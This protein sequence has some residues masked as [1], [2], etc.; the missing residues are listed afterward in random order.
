M[1][2]RGFAAAALPPEVEAVP[3]DDWRGRTPMGAQKRAV[4]A[5]CARAPHEARGLLSAIEAT[6]PEALLVDQLA[7]GAIAAA[8]AWGGPWAR[9][10]AFPVP[11]PGG[12]P[13]GPGFPPARGPLGRLRD[14]V[15]RRA[16]DVGLD[17]LAGPPLARVRTELGLPPLAGGVEIFAASPLQVRL[18][19]EPFE[20]PFLEHPD[21]VLM[22]G[23]CVWEPAGE[24]P[25]ELAEVEEPLV[26][27]ATSTEFQDD[28]RL[29]ATALA[30]LADEPLHVVATMPT[31]R[32]GGLPAPANATLLA[33]APHMPI[34]AR[35]ACAI[36]HGGMGVTQ[37]SLS[38]G[39]P[40]CAVPFGRDQPEVARRVE[41]ARA[42][43][44][45]PAR[46]LSAGRLRRKVLEAIAC[47]AGAE[48][49]GAGFA[50]AGG[51]AAAA[52]AVERRLL[53][54]LSP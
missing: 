53:G 12:P 34:L 19:A 54:L 48:R 6:S 38:L 44:R 41:V 35:S 5:V 49:V 20:Y 47:R 27:V 14:T 37:K 21:D 17:R 23:P 4:T 33:F 29:V 28:G 51:P 15:F 16:A 30:A 42:G 31:A 9:Y 50:A 46:R 18:T 8:E 1:R 32:P 52:N 26:L 39:V 45:L 3:M 43:T 22:V 25:R 40:V 7:W 36:T 24:L 10:C 2:S 13:P 11:S